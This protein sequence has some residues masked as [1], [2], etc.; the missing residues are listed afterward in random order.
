MWPSSRWCIIAVTINTS[1]FT[2]GYYY[3]YKVMCVGET[4]AARTVLTLCNIQENPQK[5]TRE[6]QDVFG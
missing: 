2:E 3:P 6:N 4:Y 5:N 1:G